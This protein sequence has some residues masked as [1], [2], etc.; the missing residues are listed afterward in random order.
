MGFLCGKTLKN[1]VDNSCRPW[2]SI[3]IKG[4]IVSSLK[5]NERQNT[6]TAPWIILVIGLFL[7]LFGIIKNDENIKLL[8]FLTI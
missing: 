4:D 7:F 1:S 3:S 8:G 6:M 2:Y 5:K